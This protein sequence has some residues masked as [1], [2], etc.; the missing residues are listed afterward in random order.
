MEQLEKCHM[1]LIYP[2]LSVSFICDGNMMVKNIIDDWFELC[3]NKDNYN[4]EYY[5]N[6][7]TE[8]YLEMFNVS[9]ELINRYVFEEAYPIGLP[10]Q[11]LS[12]ADENQFLKIAVTFAYRTWRKGD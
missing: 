6:Y 1:N 9:N 11:T 3:I 5:D 10:S 12:W 7:T 2:E 8:L 4:V